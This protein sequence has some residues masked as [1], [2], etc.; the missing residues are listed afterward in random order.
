MTRVP[1]ATLLQLVDVGHGVTSG[2]G[3]QAA[4]V[5]FEHGA[6]RGR[7]HLQLLTHGGNHPDVFIQRRPIDFGI[8]L[9]DGI[10][11]GGEVTVS[12]VEHI[13]SLAGRREARHVALDLDEGVCR[14]P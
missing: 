5:L 10:D 14:F 2:D 12:I 6:L 1:R 3:H 9:A 13:S 4:H 8:G 11:I 7:Q